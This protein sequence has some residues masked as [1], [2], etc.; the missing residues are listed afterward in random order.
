MDDSCRQTGGHYLGFVLLV[1]QV[2]HDLPV[3]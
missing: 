3:N 2:R 1:N